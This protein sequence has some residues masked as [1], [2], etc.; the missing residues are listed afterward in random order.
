MIRASTYRLHACTPSRAR[1]LR[2]LTGACRLVWNHFLWE[3]QRSYVTWRA[4]KYRLNGTTLAGK[5]PHRPS[6]SFFS[7]G[8]QFTKL[9]KET[10]WLQE[11]PFKVVRYT[12]KRQADAWRRAFKYGGFPKFKGRYAS[13]GFT[14][15]ENVRIKIGAVTGIRRLYVPKI[16]WCILSRSGNC[17]HDGSQAKQVVVKRINGKWYA[18][19]FYEVPD[20]AVADNGLAVGIDRNVGQIALSTGDI[21]RLPDTARLEAR[22][23]RYQRI[24]ARRVNGSNRK[25]LARYRCAKVSR[26]LA[27]IRHN[28]AHQASRQIADAFGTVVMEDLKTKGM[29][30]SAKGTAENPGKNV[31]AKAGLNRSI[32]ASAWG[33]LRRDLEYKAAHVLGVNAAYTSQMCHACGVIDKRSRKSQSKF[34]CPQCGYEG[35]ADVNA[36]LNILARGVGVAGREGGGVARP[37]KCQENVR[38]GGLAAVNLSI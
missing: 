19:V 5:M 21:I 31:K 18:T 27:M 20:A 11:L 22:K 15:P 13:S 14:I 1:K 10:P 16:G 25:N 6:V 17:P 36:A 12:L 28:W 2:Q 33:A 30:A 4:W 37:V 3:S 35:N 9:R 26:E 8:K 24:M 34:E 23:R 32:L 7:L 38:V 29:T